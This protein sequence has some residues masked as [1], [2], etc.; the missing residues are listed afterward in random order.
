MN[1]N[2]MRTE[3]YQEESNNEGTFQDYY[4][5]IKEEFDLPPI[6]ELARLD[7]SAVFMAYSWFKNDN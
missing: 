4:D 2:E 6:N 5:N 3:S 7:S 1:N